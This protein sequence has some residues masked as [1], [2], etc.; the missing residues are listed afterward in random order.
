L[1]KQYV[2]VEDAKQCQ[3]SQ[4]LSDSYVRSAH[5]AN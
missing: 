3:L 2:Q 1:E 4:F 5:T